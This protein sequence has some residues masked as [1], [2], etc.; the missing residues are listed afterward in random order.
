[1]RKR[2]EI[3][4]LYSLSGT[5]RLP[6]ESC[7]SGALSAI[8]AVNADPESPIEI[9]PVERDPAGNIDRYAPLA[10]DIL[11]NTGAR[12][13]I[14][15]ITSWSRKE[16]IPALEK[17]G[18]TLWY[19]APYEGFEASDNVVYM[20]ACP[21]QHILPLITYVI[22]RFG[23]RAFLVG[24]NY[25]WGWEVNRVARDLIGD[26]GG[27][28]LGE[29][30]L[31]LGDEDVGRLIAELRT[32][33]PNFILN[34]FVGATSYAFFEAY[35]ALAREDEWF[36]PETCP[37]ISCNLT[38]AELPAIGT[39]GDG[40]L[41]AGPF[42]DIGGGST[43]TGLRSSFMMAAHSA[44]LVLAEMLM[45]DAGIERR[46]DF[47]G[48]T[49]D[50]PLGRIAIDPRTHHTHLPVRIARIAGGRFELVEDHPGLVAPDPYLSRYDPH[51]AFGRANLRVV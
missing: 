27:M 29:R 47:A 40:H 12:H 3:G 14:G 23:A 46:L 34:N 19:A 15:C 37:L 35:A 11:R 8:A 1:M 10:E 30:Y 44:V 36:R 22:P 20:H 7:R 41:S 13:I 17:H 45:R 38:E 26:A 42:F 28:V 21:N 49:F 9:V 25:I 33:R 2:I 32:Q 51:T 31:A 18:G 39:A 4:L 16:V 50:T 6:S 48:R 43:A 5:Y 24:S